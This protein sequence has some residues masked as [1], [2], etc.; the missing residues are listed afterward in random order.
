MTKE[1][2]K[3]GASLATGT[4]EE[5]CTALAPMSRGTV[6]HGRKKDGFGV[7]GMEE[8]GARR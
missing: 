6:F 4:S 3:T 2:T 5:E 1:T 8:V 7:V